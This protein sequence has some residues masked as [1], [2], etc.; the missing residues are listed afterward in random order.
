MHSSLEELNH[1]IEASGRVLP[2]LLGPTFSRLSVAKRGS[3]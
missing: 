1:I 2:D 3:S